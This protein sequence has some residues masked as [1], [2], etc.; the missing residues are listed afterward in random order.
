MQ[1]DELVSVMN[2]IK[3]ERI[4]TALSSPS[5][6]SLNEPPL[7]SCQT[8]TVSSTMNELSVEGPEIIWRYGGDPIGS[9]SIASDSDLT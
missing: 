8:M 2:F 6:T 7:S 1:H 4:S 3:T 5:A 9:A